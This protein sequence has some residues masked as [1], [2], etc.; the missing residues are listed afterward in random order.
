MLDI[1]FYKKQNNDNFVPC[2][3]ELCDEDYEK[4]IVLNFAKRFHFEKQ[5]LIV[6]EE[7]YSIDAVHCD[8]P[9]LT[10]AKE[11]CNRLLFEELG[12]V[13]NY[14]EKIEGETINKSKLNFM[15]VLR[16]VLSNLSEC[17]YFSY[18]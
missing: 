18:V 10:G 12:K 17:Q 8:A 1:T 16:D 3:I 6:E 7:E 14:C 5:R 4:L 11:I 13:K 9:V 2:T 15:F